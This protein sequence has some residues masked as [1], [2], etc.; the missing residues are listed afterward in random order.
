M[1]LVCNKFE[2]MILETEQLLPGFQQNPE[3]YI[4]LNREMNKNE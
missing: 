4:N 1:I 3:K 2:A